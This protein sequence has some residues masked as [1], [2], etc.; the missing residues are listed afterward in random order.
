MNLTSDTIH[1]LGIVGC[2]LSAIVSS[3]CAVYAAY[4]TRPAPARPAPGPSL[5]ELA[6][7]ERRREEAWS[8]ARALGRALREERKAGAPT[9]VAP[10]YHA[11]RVES[12][13]R[14]RARGRSDE[15]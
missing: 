10:R 11:P 7:A 1:N 5:T 15:S 12:H 3:A 9:I 14:V 6:A 8:A 2:A 4:V 13:S